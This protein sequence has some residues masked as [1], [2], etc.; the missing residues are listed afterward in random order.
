MDQKNEEHYSLP[1][2]SSQQ[3][4]YIQTIYSDPSLIV[5]KFPDRTF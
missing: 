1:N 4:S 3:L 5:L 2:D